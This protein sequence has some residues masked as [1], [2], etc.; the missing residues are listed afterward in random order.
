ML[1]PIHIDPHIT[2]RPFREGDAAPIFEI[3]DRDREY[4]AEFLPWV[5]DMGTVEDEA[6]FVEITMSRPTTGSDARASFVIEYQ[7]EIAGIIEVRLTNPPARIGTIG[8]W[9]AEPMQ[10]KGIMTRSCEAVTAH[11]FAEMDLRR[12]EIYAD[13][14]NPKSRAIPLR[15]GYSEDGVVPYTMPISGKTQPM[16]AYSMTAE[17]WRARNSA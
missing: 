5:E 3:I 1:T 17:N 13:P 12:I 14:E 11:G 10:R 4:L 16:A 2:L 8:Y 9:L 6:E 7:S 15:L